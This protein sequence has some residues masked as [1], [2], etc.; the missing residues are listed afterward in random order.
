MKIVFFTN[1]YL[2]MISG[3]VTTINL[4][5]RG[6]IAKGHEVFIF[7]PNY[8]GWKDQ[9]DKVYRSPAVNLSRKIYYPLPLPY[10]PGLTA[11]LRRIQPE[12]IH[13][14]HPFLLGNA[15]LVQA[16]KLHIPVV[17]TY[18]TQYEQY[19]HYFPFPGRL[20]RW[21][22]RFFVKN[23]IRRIDLLVTPADSVKELIQEYGLAK[24]IEILPNPVEI[25]F[26]QKADRMAMRKRYSIGDC[27]LLLSVGRLGHEKNLDLI[28]KSFSILHRESKADLRLMLVGAGP[29]EESLRQ[30]ARELGI[31]QQVIFTGLV[32]QED[33][34]GIYQ[35]ADLFLMASTTETFGI[36]IIEAM[37]AGLPVIA[38]E[39]KGSKDIII[40]GH[41]GILTAEDPQAFSAAIKSLHSNENRRLAMSQAAR[42]S[43]VRYSVENLTDELVSLY[44]E[45]IRH[46]QERRYSFNEQA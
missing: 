8:K 10:S 16:K 45:A 41:N 19:A 40:S 32:K 25:S 23:F 17:F 6:L 27:F 31:D 36:V 9:E 34:P 43:A 2:P 13:C 33:L 35:A 12:I 20:V 7:A 26:N 44:E 30:Y 38:V 4:F 14:H 24:E 39:A 42:E 29:A 11:L 15:G 1:A 21:V 37:A 3:V 5:R 46:S 18:H 28:L 22:T